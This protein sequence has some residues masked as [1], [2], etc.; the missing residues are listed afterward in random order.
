[1]TYSTHAFPH[2]ESLSPT[3]AEEDP[4]YV[5][6][7]ASALKSIFGEY[8]EVHQPDRDAPAYAKRRAVHSAFTLAL[9]TED[10]TLGELSSLLPPWA[11][12]V[13]EV[14]GVA[15]VSVTPEV[16]ATAAYAEA[17]QSESLA[18]AVEQLGEQW[19]ANT[20]VLVYDSLGVLKNRH[21][22]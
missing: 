4:E 8:Q 19:D 14:R 2:Y 11:E 17:V 9:E 1:M 12:G 15:D 20:L 10:Q 7:T 22:D 6:E 13:A 21:V 16:L 3:V 5:R 18:W